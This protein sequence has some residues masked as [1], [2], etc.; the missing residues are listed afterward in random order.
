MSYAVIKR[1]SRRLGLYRH[2]RWIHRHVLDRQDLDTFRRDCA[3]YGQFIKRGD[4]CFD[5]G[6]NY[7]LKTEVFLALGARVVAFEPQRDCW[8]EILDRNPRA[9]AIC[10]AV[11]SAPGA[12]TL[13]VDRHRTGS[14]LVQGWRSAVEGT[15]QVPVTTLDAAIQEYGLPAF[16]KIDVEGYDL[17][18]L[19]GLS[20]PIRVVSFEFHRTRIDAALEC[21]GYLRRFGPAE[22]NV[23][24]AE[25]QDFASPVWMTPSQAETLLTRKVS[26][27]EGYDWGD[28]FVRFLNSTSTK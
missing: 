22:I 12:L 8:Q 27:A 19:R 3:F 24:G 23:T 28:I 2:A 11:G 13:Y 20:Q 10:A 5:V 25:G 17:E 14:S 9:I 18:V 7:G 21:L 26:H 15:E 1:I 6:A 4:L 16:C